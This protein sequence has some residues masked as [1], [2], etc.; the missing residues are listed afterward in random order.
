MNIINRIFKAQLEKRNGKIRVLTANWVFNPTKAQ[1]ERTLARGQVSLSERSD[2]NGVTMYLIHQRGVRC[3]HAD[4][5]DGVHPRSDS[6]GCWFVP[7]YICRKCEFHQKGRRRG[8]P[9]YPC[10]KFK[11]TDDPGA[12]ALGDTVAVL[13]SAVKRANEMMGE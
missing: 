1:T 8:T 9:R 5:C 4:L 6:G 13:D 2:G 11:A 7:L 10:C 3:T 12:H